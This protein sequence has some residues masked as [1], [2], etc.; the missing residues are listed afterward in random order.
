MTSAR[1]ARNGNKYLPARAMDVSVDAA[2]ALEFARAA[3][4]RHH[5]TP[6]GAITGGVWMFR[7]GT[8]IDE[9]FSDILGLGV[10]YRMIG[11]SD[12]YARIAVWTE[13]LATGTRLTVSL[14]T[15]IFQA[16]TV[17]TTITELIGDFTDA[18]VLIQAGEPFSGIDLPADSPGQPFPRRRAREE[19]RGA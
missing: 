19:A 10:F 3:M 1:R 9:F 13:P 18:G 17:Q 11:R 14:V 2:A 15:G 12:A 7:Y 4:A 5:F 8:P 6:H 16:P